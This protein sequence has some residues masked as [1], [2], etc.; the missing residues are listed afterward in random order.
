VC[1]KPDNPEEPLDFFEPVENDLKVPGIC[2][3]ELLNSPE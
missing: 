1:V 3:Y 2:T